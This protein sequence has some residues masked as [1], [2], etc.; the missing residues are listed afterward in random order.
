M[1]SAHP[2]TIPEPRWRRLPEERPRQILEAALEVFG[3]RG[4]AGARLD[5]IA[6]RPGVSKGTIY[7]YFPSKEALFVEVIREMVI[8]NIERQA[9]R[10]G[11]GTPTEQL[12]DY[13]R[14][15]WGYVRSPAFP[16]VHRLITAE[17][18]HFPDLV[19]F[20]TEEVGARTI[21]VLADILRSGVESGE[22]RPLDAEATARML[23]AMLIKHGEWCAHRE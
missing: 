15:I 19:R 20:F 2:Q 16:T 10:L 14:A 11:T 13:V 5:D 23:H 4:L 21:R 18:H 17:L 1:T 9:G 8:A 6:K 22:F 3:E 7:L 12:R